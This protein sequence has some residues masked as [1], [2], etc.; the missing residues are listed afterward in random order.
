MPSLPQIPRLEWSARDDFVNREADLEAME[1]WWSGRTRDAL[2]LIGRRRVGKSW[3][4]RRFADGKPSVILVA[5][6]LMVGT[7]LARFAGE[8]EPLFGVRPQIDD[9]PALIRL[10]YQA[11]RDQKLLAII[12]ELPYLLPRGGARDATLSAVQA[13]MEQERDDSK[14]K[15]VV[16]GSLLGQMETLLAEKSPLHGRLQ[17]LDVWP[18]DFDEARHL[19]NPNAGAVER[20]ERYA[21]AGGMARYLAELGEG[22]RL[23]TLVCRSA[24]DRRGPLFNDPRAVLEQE[25]QEPAT[26]FSILAELADHPVQIE[27]LTNT[28]GL[29]AG[30]LA[31]YLETLQQMRLIRAEL[32]VGAPPN[33]RTTR[34]AVT[35]GFIR[36][37][38]RFVLPSQDAL[39]SGLDPADLW[40]AEIEDQLAAYVSPT[41]EEICRRWTRRTHGAQAPH[42][43]GW[44]GNALNEHRKTG[45]RT[46]EEIDVAGAK[47]KNLVVAGE[48]KWTSEPMELEVLADLQRFKIPAVEQE[49]RLKVAAGGPLILLFSKS[50]FTNALRGTADADPKIR[51]IEPDEIVA[52]PS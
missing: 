16:C 18:L 38:F 20:I 27:K 15:L 23:K 2:C 44:W 52:D 17:R 46:Q 33:A 1:Q 22:G 4:F 51:L 13:V 31:P 35:D 10:L 25:L 29:R 7:Q 21:V 28:L 3:L 43:G 42:F 36:F 32:P 40:R 41:F 37:W 19:M 50:G 26:Y 30:R 9:L 45:A 5:D 39:Q 14:T 34:Y 8:L 6:Q 24:L 48:C 11:G 49:G 12:D 47:N